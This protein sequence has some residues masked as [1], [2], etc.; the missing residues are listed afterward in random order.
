MEDGSKTLK[1]V[2]IYNWIKGMIARNRFVVGEKLPTETEIS[3]M[4]SI[5]RMTVRK[6]MDLLVS[7]GVITRTPGRGTYL[8]GKD[9]KVTYLLDHIV[10]F[11]TMAKENN[12]KSSYKVT[13]RKL[14]AASDNVLEELMLLPNSMVV[15]LVRVIFGN[16]VPM[17]IERSFLP[18][19][20]SKFV[21]ELDLDQPSLYA[22][23]QKRT[24]GIALNHAFQTLVAGLLSE[25]EKVL[26]QYPKEEPVAC[27][28]QKNIIY[29]PNSIP[30]LEF[31]AIFPYD[32]FQ[33]QVHS[34]SYSTSILN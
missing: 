28:R 6:A 33:F 20:E 2:K 24:G 34:G 16:D 5:N 27:I 12:L 13:E 1:H 29:D 22:T 25:D 11:E 23:I 10:S 31:N 18:Y 21:F 32:K 3:K 19:P 9:D 8:T 14:M 30:V 26:L 17:Y 7:E 4:F 15:S